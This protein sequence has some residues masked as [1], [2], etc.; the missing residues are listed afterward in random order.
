MIAFSRQWKFI[1][2]A[3]GVSVAIDRALGVV[4]GLL[5]GEASEGQVA[6]LGGLFLIQLLSDHLKI[7]LT[8][9]DH[10]S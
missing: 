5:H 1:E 2:E 8:D 4:E 7:S 9:S 10:P 6:I 3:R